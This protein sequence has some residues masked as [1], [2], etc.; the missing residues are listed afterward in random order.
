M[1][2][3]VKD[4]KQ[5]SII[6]DKLFKAIYKSVK[7]KKRVSIILD[8]RDVYKTNFV[9]QNKIISDFY[10]EMQYLGDS[11]L[12]SI[13]RGHIWHTILMERNTLTTMMSL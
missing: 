9:K 12:D 6:L 10:S 1:H 13:Q 4:T 3:A 2:T 8:E 11:I 7:N 5:I